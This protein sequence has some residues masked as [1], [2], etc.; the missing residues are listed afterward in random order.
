ML[1]SLV[2]L[3]S[4]PAPQQP[5]VFE[6]IVD[7]SAGL[8]QARIV[9]I[10][11]RS[12]D[13]RLFATAI[14]GRVHIV[15]DGV[16]DPVPFLDVSGLVTATGLAGLRA[17]A[18]HPDYEQNGFVYLWYDA[19][20]SA[21]GLD[22]VLARMTRDATD[23]DRVDPASLAEILRFPEDVRG[24]GGGTL[25]F[26]PDG[27]LWVGAGDGGIQHD[28]NC[29]AQD[30]A[31]LLGKILRIDVDHGA[32]YSIP[33]D[34]PFVG[35]PGHA[36]EVAQLGFRHPWKWSF[37]RLTGDLW[38]GDVGQEARE[39]VN[40]AAGG[41]LGVN[42]GW[43]V[44]EGETCHVVGGSAGG[45]CAPGTSACGDPSFRVP[46]FAYDHSL[47]CSITGGYV[48]RGSAI[49]ELVGHYVST[50]FCTRRTW[51]TLRTASGFETVERSV[52]IRPATAQPITASSFGEDGDGELLLVDHGSGSVFRMV[53]GCVATTTCLGEPN[54]L[55][56]AGT[57]RFNG[58]TAYSENLVSISLGTLPP[59]TPALLFVGPETADVAVGGGRLCV[60]GSLLRL[61]VQFASGGGAALFPLDLTAPPFAV[62]TGSVVGPGSTVTFQAWYRDGGAGGSNFTSAT[63]VTFCP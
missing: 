33:A 63:T 11:G 45:S 44:M 20:G 61:G 58:S 23:P 31:S 57:L 46:A 7:P 52:E 48:Y 28:P 53:R 38:I 13:D 3:A 24:H 22:L 55:G 51:T 56:Q 29:R 43:P 41:E 8:G 25:T 50:D 5:L 1:A 62:G 39:E 12:D 34:N 6:R 27:M 37:D 59:Q 42:F 30:P 2:L 54:S 40:F 9:G 14:D 15:R 35:L 60:G 32:P 49:P 19:P 4:F 26:G 36:P 16:V 18:F 47:G 10:T 17:T 21:T